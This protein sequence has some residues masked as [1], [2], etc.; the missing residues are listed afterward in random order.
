LK[1]IGNWILLDVEIGSSTFSG[2]PCQI[3]DISYS[4]NGL[5][6]PMRIWSFAMLPF[7]TWNPGY[8]GIVGGQSAT[9][10]AE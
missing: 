1:D 5:K 3:R 6:L 10:I 7:G 2:V 9:I 8:T 4:P